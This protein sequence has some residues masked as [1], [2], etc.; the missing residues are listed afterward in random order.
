MKLV[1]DIQQ[2]KENLSRVSDQQAEEAIKTII[3][4]LGENPNREGLLKTPHRAAKS[5]EFLTSGYREDVNNIINN[6]VEQSFNLIYKEL[7]K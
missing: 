1:K 5:W 3:E 4:W 7:I 6:A 2:N